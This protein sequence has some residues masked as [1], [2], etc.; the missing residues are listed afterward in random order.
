MC[1]RDR[2]IAADNVELYVQRVG[3]EILSELTV[4]EGKA[5]LPNEKGHYMLKAILSLGNDDYVQL[6]SRYR[7]Y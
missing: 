2:V 7:V 6:I 4:K 1:I 3:D 5:E